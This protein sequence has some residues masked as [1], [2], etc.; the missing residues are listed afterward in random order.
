MEKRL[1]SSRHWIVWSFVVLNMNWWW[2]APSLPSNATGST[3]DLR[4]DG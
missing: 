3:N 2:S 1:L 4:T